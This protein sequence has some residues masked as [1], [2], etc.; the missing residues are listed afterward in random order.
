MDITVFPKGTFDLYE[1]F[2]GDGYYEIGLDELDFTVLG[3]VYDGGDGFLSL[4]ENQPLKTF[5]HSKV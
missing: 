1:P 3:Y 2:D 4:D 5:I